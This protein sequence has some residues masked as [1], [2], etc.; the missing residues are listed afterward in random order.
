MFRNVNL[1]RDRFAGKDLR[2]REYNFKAKRL[3]YIS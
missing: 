2:Y 1:V 3:G